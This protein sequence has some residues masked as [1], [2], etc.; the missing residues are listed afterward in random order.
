MQPKISM[1]LTGFLVILISFYGCAG[2]KKEPVNKSYFDLAITLPVSSQNKVCKSE[3][4]L[5]KE[6]YINP[7]FDSHSFV[8]RLGT[9]KYAIDYY[10][11]FV[12]SPARLIT[13]GIEGSLCASNLFT[14]IKTN[15]KQNISF[16]LSGKI[17]RL[18]GDFQDLSNFRAVI[19]IRI[20]LE[21]G[22]GTAFQTISSKTYLAEEKILSNDPS[23]L[24]SGWN[25]GLLKIVIE[26]ISD[27]QTI[28]LP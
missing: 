26:F 19:E 11:E 5:V 3:T 2:L 9:N 18:Y 15:K 1:V 16:R 6:F 14:S 20:T 23:K 28:V 21:K 12:S 27:F 7:V 10:N 24:V 25:T 4:L 8:Y 13:Q 22:N 17:T